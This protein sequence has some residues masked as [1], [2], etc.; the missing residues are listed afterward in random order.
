[1]KLLQFINFSSDIDIET[2]ILEWSRGN[3]NVLMLLVIVRIYSF[4]TAIVLGSVTAGLSHT[5]ALTRIHK[6]GDNYGERSE[7]KNF[8]ARGGI[9]NPETA[10]L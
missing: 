7:P 5:G 8:F 4:N 2:I 6:W 3:K 10:K 1:M 9:I